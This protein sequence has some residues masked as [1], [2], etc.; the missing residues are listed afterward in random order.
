M[1]IALLGV[2]GQIGNQLVPYF[3]LKNHY[4]VWGP[5]REDLNLYDTPLIYDIICEQ[6]PELIINTA[7]YTDVDGAERFKDLADKINHQ[8]VREIAKAAKNLDVPLIHF[9]T[10]YVFD[11][12]KEDKYTEKDKPHPLGNYGRSKLAGDEAIL[13][14]EPKG[15][16]FRTSWIYDWRRINFFLKMKFVMQP[17]AK[18]HVIDDQI[19]TPNPAQLLAQQVYWYIQENQFAK[20]N[21]VNLVCD[22]HTSWF[23]FAKTIC[24]HLRKDPWVKVIPVSTE[25]YLGRYAKD[26]IVA[27]R[28]RNA[29]LDN[30]KA[31]NSGY[32]L[33][34]WKVAFADFIQKPH[35]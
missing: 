7:A 30:T 23:N 16:I 11:G 24:S 22:D 25:K 21:I 34:N 13:S 14:I 5:N 32:H 15:I 4:D 6:K 18:I 17:G 1:K 26:K 28:P 29:V 12:K 27:M 33:P 35:K 31:K 10:D 2:R 19:G 9:S 3:V 8:A 20:V